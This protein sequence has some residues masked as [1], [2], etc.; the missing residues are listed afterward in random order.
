MIDME[1]FLGVDEAG[2][3]GTAEKVSLGRNYMLLT[4]IY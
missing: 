3:F 4:A 1:V 2:E